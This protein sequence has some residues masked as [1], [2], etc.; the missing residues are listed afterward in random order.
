MIDLLDALFRRE[1][2]ISDQNDQSDKGREPYLLK[3]ARE[4]RHIYAENREK[5]QND[6]DDQL[7]LPFPYAGV[8]LAVVLFHDRVDDGVNILFRSGSDS[9]GVVFHDFRL[10]CFGAF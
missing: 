5:S 3:P 7:R 2:D 10:F 1:D 8:R 9:S 4:K 6:R